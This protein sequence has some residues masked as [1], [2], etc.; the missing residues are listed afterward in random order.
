[1]AFAFIGAGTNSIQ[2]LYFNSPQG[3]LTIDLGEKEWTSD[4]NNIGLHLYLM[5]T[6]RY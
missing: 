3:M 1:M 6:M 2:L 5:I 4:E